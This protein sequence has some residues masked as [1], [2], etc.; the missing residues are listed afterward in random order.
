MIN[1]VHP[2]KQVWPQSQQKTSAFTPM[3]T[4]KN[5]KKRES[6]SAK[7]FH[8]PATEPKKKS[9]IESEKRLAS[10]IKAQISVTDI[11]A[12]VPDEKDKTPILQA[13]TVQAHSFLQQAPEAMAYIPTP[14]GGLISVN[15]L[16]DLINYT[17]YMIGKQNNNKLLENSQ[18]ATPNSDKE[19]EE[20]EDEEEHVSEE[21]EEQK[22]GISENVTED[23]KYPDLDSSEFKTSKRFIK[24]LEKEDEK[25]SRHSVSESAKDSDDSN[26]DDM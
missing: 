19:G 26:N 4:K 5:S 12:F 16:K 21:F 10:K 11:P 8:E 13:P 1:T 3:Q 17:N 25:M 9:P 22:S 20:V 18:E 7:A 2:K 15:N 14:E 24:Q 23:R 6:N